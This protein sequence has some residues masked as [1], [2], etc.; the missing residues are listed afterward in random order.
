MVHPM[1]W[2]NSCSMRDDIVA[3]NKCAKRRQ[4]SDGSSRSAFL[5]SAARDKIRTEG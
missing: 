1:L 5:S 4:E 2:Q 3:C